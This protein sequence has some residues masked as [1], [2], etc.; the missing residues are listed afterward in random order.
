MLNAETRA[1]VERVS[2]TL[3]GNSRLQALT[4]DTGEAPPIGPIL[5]MGGTEEP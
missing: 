4:D 1:S 5:D 3:P 2:R